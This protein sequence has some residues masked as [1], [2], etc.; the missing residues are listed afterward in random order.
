MKNS[1][2][3]R[4]TSIFFLALF[5]IQSAV[6]YT[7]PFSF[8]AGSPISASQM[9]ANF[10]YVLNALSA[11]QQMTIY[12]WGAGGGGNIGWGGSVGGPGGFTSL[13]INSTFTPGTTL[14]V[15]VGKGGITNSDAQGTG[16]GYAGVFLGTPSQANALII[17]G[18]GGGSAYS[19]AISGAGGNPAST[20]TSAASG[21][22]PTIA[23]GG[24]G[25]IGTVSNGG[26]GSSLQGGYGGGSSYSISYGGGGNVSPNVGGGGG[27]GGGYYGGG[28]GAV[29]SGYI[30][31]GGAGGLS[32]YTS[33]YGGFG[34]YVSGFAGTMTAPN[35]A[36]SYYTA[37]AAMGGSNTSGATTGGNGLVVIINKGIVTTF[38]YTGANQTYTIP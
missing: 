6:A 5:W 25:G 33:A 12:A 29:T 11:L 19:S 7:L 37:N 8:S 21:G 10:A 15:V 4:I 13:T 31:V 34:A 35:T 16:G 9:N 23:A 18:G 36:S 32:Y 2:I 17:A 27:G 20:G 28:G 24:T 30:N 22:I 3:N 14:T 1:N 26:A 38:T